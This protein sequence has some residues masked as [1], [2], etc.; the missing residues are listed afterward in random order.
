MGK[1]VCVAVWL[2]ARMASVHCAAAWTAS[3]CCVGQGGGAEGGGG[4]SSAETGLIPSA[5]R[6]TQAA[7]TMWGGL[8]ARG[9]VRLGEL[10]WRAAFASDPFDTVFICGRAV[11]MRGRGGRSVV[12]VRGHAQGGVNG[13]GH[14]SGAGQW[15][16]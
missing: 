11:K 16:M 5:W 15:W 13:R 14:V 6:G 12:D 2:P 10:L 8:E 4:G 7:T 9:G 3:A 1:S